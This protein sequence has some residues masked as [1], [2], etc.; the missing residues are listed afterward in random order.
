MKRNRIL[1]II[2]AGVGLALIALFVRTSPPTQPLVEGVGERAPTQEEP[3]AR[4]ESGTQEAASEPLPIM[5]LSARVRSP[6]ARLEFEISEEMSRSA[7]IDGHE[8]VVREWRGA[9]SPDIRLIDAAQIGQVVAL[10]LPDG[11]V[12]MQVLRVK[13]RDERSGVVSGR[14][15]GTRFGEVSLSYA[16]DAVA[17]SIRIPESNTVYEIRNAGDGQQFVASIDVSKLGECG[18]EHHGHFASAQHGGHR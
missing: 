9:F 12:A 6:D 5:D 3:L 10:R 1:A 7:Q 17:G 16:N 15:E 13:R 8:H 14:I 4:V 2:V 18:L 11:E